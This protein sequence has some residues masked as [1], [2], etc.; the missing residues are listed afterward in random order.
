M[1]SDYLSNQ[2]ENVGFYL[3]L[4]RIWLILIRSLLGT[5]LL[6]PIAMVLINEGVSVVRT[7]YPALLLIHLALI[8]V[9][10]VIAQLLTQKYGDGR[11]L[12]GI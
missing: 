6:A 7:I 9:Y 2:P 5:L 11:D 8:I 1:A 4:T 10:A 3:Q 12:W